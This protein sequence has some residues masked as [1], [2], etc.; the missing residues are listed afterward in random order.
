MA[1][2]LSGTMTT[3][4]IWRYLRSSQAGCQCRGV[5][6]VRLTDLIDWGTKWALIEGYRIDLAW[7]LTNVPALLSAERLVVVHGQ[8]GETYET[9]TARDKTTESIPKPRR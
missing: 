4:N 8:A 6:G 1:A 7:L 3:F 2:L 9:K 5:I